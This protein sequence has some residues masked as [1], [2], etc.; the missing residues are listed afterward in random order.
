MELAWDLLVSIQDGAMNT[1]QSMIVLMPAGL[2][3]WWL[4]VSAFSWLAHL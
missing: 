1:I 2:A 4:I 3:M